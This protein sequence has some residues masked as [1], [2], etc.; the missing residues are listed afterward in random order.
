MVAIVSGAGLG[1]SLGSLALLGSR[2]QLGQAA[3]GANRER[4]YVNI[5]T[6]NLVVQDQDALLGGVGPNAVIA[7]S[8]TTP[9]PVPATSTT[10]WAT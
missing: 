6:G 8:P 5:A 10:A 9:W 7:A 3:F 4:V 1:V 2:G